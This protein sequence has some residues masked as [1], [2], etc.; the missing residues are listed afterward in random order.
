MRHESRDEDKIFLYKLLVVD[1]CT[2]H[3]MVWGVCIFLKSWANDAEDL[4]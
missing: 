3:Y 2:R 4:G 1:G